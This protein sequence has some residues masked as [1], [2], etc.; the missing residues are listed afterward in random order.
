MI[1]FRSFLGMNNILLC[2]CA[3][4]V[5]YLF[6]DG[7]LG[8]FHILTIVNIATVNMVEWYHINII[9]SHVFNMYPVVLDHIIVVFF[10]V[11]WF[12]LSTVK[13]F[14]HGV[15]TTDFHP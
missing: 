11:C 14:F 3:L 13:L 12:V 5:L 15:Y 4:H 7:L 9:I 10:F 1:G 8:W 2:M 6:D